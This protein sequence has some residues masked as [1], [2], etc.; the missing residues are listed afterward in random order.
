MLSRLFSTKNSELDRIQ[1]DLTNQRNAINAFISELKT[2]HKRD[3]VEWCTVHGRECQSTGLLMWEKDINHRYTFL[4]SRHCNDFYE[5]SLANVRTLIGKDDVQLIKEFTERTGKSN[6][7]GELCVS[8]DQYTVNAGKSCRFWELGYIGNRILILDVTKKPK[9]SAAGKLI[10]TRG[11]ALNTSNREC[12]IKQLLEVFLKT[13]EAEYLSDKK[14][15]SPVSNGRSA[16]YLINKKKN[17][18][19]GNF[20]R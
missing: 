17:P 19:N 1:N 11:W 10:G 18:F 16:V 7:F 5:T 4:N 6:S 3:R 13:G 8:S 9:Y 2:S 20:P 12:E 14:N 15:V